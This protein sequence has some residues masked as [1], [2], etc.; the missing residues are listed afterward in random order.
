MPSARSLK[1]VPA[2]GYSITSE[3]PRGDLAAAVTRFEPPDT[4]WP[5][6]LH[7]SRTLLDHR[8]ACFDKE[9]RENA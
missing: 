6:F 1:S 4:E 7:L 5:A 3:W 8:R 9:E 2:D